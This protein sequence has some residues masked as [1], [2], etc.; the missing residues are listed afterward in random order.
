[1]KL[2][3]DIVIAKYNG[4][5]RL[6]EVFRRRFSSIKVARRQAIS[7]CRNGSGCDVLDAAVNKSFSCDVLNCAGVKTHRDIIRFI[8]TH[9]VEISPVGGSVKTM[10]FKRMRFVKHRK[11]NQ[12]PTNEVQHG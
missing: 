7:L 3:T 11:V 5:E 8:K 12:Q 10:R 6:G 4:D 9:R 1:M 2:K